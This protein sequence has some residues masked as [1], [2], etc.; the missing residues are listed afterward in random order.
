MPELED[1]R[2]A[3]GGEKPELRDV[4][5]GDLHGEEVVINMGPQHPATHGVL[6]VV[7]R[8]SGETVT[9]AYPDIGYLH[10][11]VE[12][13]AEGWTYPQFVPMADRLDYTAAMANELT[14]VL[15]VERL[16]GLEVPER[17]ASIRVMFA[18]L[19]RIASHLIWLGAFGTDLGAVTMFVYGLRERESILR[20]FEMVTGARLTYSYMR[21]GGVRNDLPPEFTPKCREFLKV[22]RERIKEYDDILT[23]NPIFEARTKRVGVLTA[24]QAIALS[25]TGPNLRGSGVAY[26]VRRAQPYLIYDRLAFEVPV[27]KTGDIYDR[28]ICRMLEIRQSLGIIEQCLD[29]L[30]GGEVMAK[31]PKVIKPPAGEVYSLTEAPRGANAV[32][33]VSDGSANPYR[34]H[35]RAP[36]FANLQVI[37]TTATGYKLADAVATIAS[38]D[39]VLGEVDR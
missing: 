26:D 25:A 19:Q 33:I 13:I 37:P 35:W 29:G 7:L 27:G 11:G 2:L 9:G 6:R 17:A 24:D 1:F 34:L 36:T 23:G 12:K 16:L 20:L 5:T 21:I 28:Y 3:T 31:V 30:P 22:M 10:R 39:I 4:V 8:L 14:Y 15:G 18:E 32:Y 38:V